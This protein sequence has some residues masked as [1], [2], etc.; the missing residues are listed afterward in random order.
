MK[1]LITGAK[2]MLAQAV[3]ERFK[4]DN[5]LILKDSSTLDITNIENIR[6]V[7]L[8]ENPKYII[9]CAAYTNVD[10]AE[11]NEELAEK[12]NGEGTKNLAIVAKENNAI[13]VH[14]STDYVFA[15]DLEINK[16]YEETDKTGPI[17]AYGR[18]KLHGEKYIEDIMD[19]YYIFRTAWLYGEGKNFVRTMIS[20]SENNNEIDVVC[21]QYGSPTYTVDLADIIYQAIQNKI[22]FGIYHATNENFTTWSDFAKKIFK[23]SNIKTKVNPIT[24]EEY[25]K[26]FPKSANRPKNSKLS[27]QKLHEN[28]I[29]ILA[30][31]DALERY[32]KKEGNI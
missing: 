6:D 3:I 22:P 28:G 1:I 12:V 21:D 15:G 11:E 17:T 8:K 10:K 20:L 9:N 27:K 24:T 2:G 31:E 26:K 5:E 19:K 30:W 25:I 18:T 4:I 16:A 29:I 14:I 13:L 23:I 7:V 32:L